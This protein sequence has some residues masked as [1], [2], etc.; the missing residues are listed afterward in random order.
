MAKIDK[1]DLDNIKIISKEAKL[2]NITSVKIKKGNYEIEISSISDLSNK[3]VVQF[4]E[5]K[6]NKEINQTWH[7]YSVKMDFKKIGKSRN[8][9][10][11]EILDKGIGTQV[12]YIPLYKKPIY[13]LES[14]KKFIKADKYYSNTLSLPMYATLKEKDVKYIVNT[15]I[16]IIS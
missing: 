12:H 1:T 11:K 16:N 3:K 13:K 7:L 10:M 15:L 6:T 2:K 9:I 8:Q 4:N 14:K 5:T